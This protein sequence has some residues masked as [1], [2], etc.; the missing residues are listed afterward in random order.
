MILGLTQM[1]GVGNMEKVPVFS[2]VKRCALLKCKV[3]QSSIIRM[4]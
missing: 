4:P 3:A 2:G 1:Q